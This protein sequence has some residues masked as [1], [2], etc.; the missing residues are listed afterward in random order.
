MAQRQRGLV[1]GG[2]QLGTALPG[3]VVEAQLLVAAGPAL[4]VSQG[5][6]L[7]AGIHRRVV[8]AL[9][10]RR[11]VAGGIAATAV[12]LVVLR[13]LLATAVV[14]RT[15]HH[16][17]VDVAFQERHQ[18]FLPAPWQHHAA[19]VVA[20]PRGHHPHPGPGTTIGRGV[21]VA[22]GVG[23]TVAGVAAALP[24]ELHLDA[25]IAVGQQRV[26]IADHDRAE[27]AGDRRPRMQV[28]AVAILGL[29]AIDHL[30]R[31]GHEAVVVERG[32]HLAGGI[33]IGQPG[34][35]AGQCRGRDAGRA[36]GLLQ[37]IKHLGIEVVARL[38]PH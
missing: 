36:Q 16:R 6:A 5:L 35:C 9:E 21:V 32:G 14:D 23:Q 37:R 27:R 38:V 4:A 30:S 10:P 15:D 31:N 19:P 1:L 7:E 24:R 25:V 3:R 2:G 33:A 17:T 11:R 34:Q 22:A 28:R 18:H 13:I 20:G 26:A 29:R 12:D 8:I